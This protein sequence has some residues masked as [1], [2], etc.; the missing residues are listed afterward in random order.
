MIQKKECA[1]R[2]CDKCLQDTNSLRSYLEEIFE[3]FDDN[4]EIRYSQWVQDG[5]MKLQNMVLN[6]QDL[7]SV[8]IKV[9]DLITYSFI[10]REQNSYLKQR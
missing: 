5:H 2:V 6:F 9:E 1:L 7:I 3:D 4:E 8:F 10:A